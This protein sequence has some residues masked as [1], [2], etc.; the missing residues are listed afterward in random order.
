MMEQLLIASHG[1]NVV[2]AGSLSLLLLMQHPS[3]E[4]NFGWD[5][6]ARQMF[7]S[8]YLTIAL[9]SIGTLLF[10]TFIADVA[11]ILFPI[12]IIYAFLCLFTVREKKNPIIWINLLLAILH[13][14][15]FASM[16][17]NSI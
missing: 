1:V 3:M 12:Q 11:L 10:R 5:S 14:V 17:T 9:L 8:I 13:S 16:F 2:L 7:A 4:K 6:P 15:S